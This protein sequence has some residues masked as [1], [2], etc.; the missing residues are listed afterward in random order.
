MRQAEGQAQAGITHPT[1]GIRVTFVRHSWLPKDTGKDIKRMVKLI[2]IFTN[3][4]V[5]DKQKAI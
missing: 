3:I 2:E 5:N 1:G 4:S